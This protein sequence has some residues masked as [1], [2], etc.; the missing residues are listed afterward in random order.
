MV[1]ILQITFSNA[2]LDWKLLYFD[3]N[4]CSQ[5]C[6]LQ[7]ASIGSDT[8]LA[9]K[10]QQAV[11]WK[12]DGLTNAY[13]CVTRPQWVKIQMKSRLKLQMSY[14]DLTQDRAPA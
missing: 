3:S 6:N 10:R 8:G 14:R 9:L 1:D 2:L 7:Q 11:A 13:K 4:I 12:N 5:G